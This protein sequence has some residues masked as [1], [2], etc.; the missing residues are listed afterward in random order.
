VTGV[1]T[2]DPPSTHDDA[3]AWAAAARARREE[4]LAGLG[5]GELSLG[6]A[7]DRARVDPLVGR[8]Y[9]LVALE[10]LPGAGKVATRRTLAGLGIEERTPLAEADAEAVLT[11][12]GGRS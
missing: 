2:A 10:A 4:L 3:L 7:F 9:L 5:S 12:F 6:E 8:V 1:A 11:A